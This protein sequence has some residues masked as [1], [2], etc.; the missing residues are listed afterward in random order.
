M[1]L[2]SAKGFVSK[3]HK[4]DSA[5]SLGIINSDLLAPRSQPLIRHQRR[6]DIRAQFKAAAKEAERSFI[7][8]HLRELTDSSSQHRSGA[9]NMACCDTQ[10]FK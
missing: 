1:K 4:P 7:K 5:H 9:A 3:L 8:I 10:E 6:T 2:L